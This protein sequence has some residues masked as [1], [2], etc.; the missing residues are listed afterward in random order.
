MYKMANVEE[1]VFDTV[2]VAACVQILTE[3]AD[4]PEA[5][6]VSGDETLR[7][8]AQVIKKNLGGFTQ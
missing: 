6:K 1:P 3:L 2:T 4:T 5:K 7:I 8:A